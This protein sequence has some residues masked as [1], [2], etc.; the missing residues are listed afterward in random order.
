MR[1]ALGILASATVLFVS[2]AVGML[3]TWSL[4]VAT[5]VG[6]VGAVLAVIIMEDREQSEAVVV[7]LA[8]RRRPTG[9]DAVDATIDA[10]V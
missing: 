9:I 8:D 7:A 5:V 1:V 6:L 2:G 4:S 10:L 3:G